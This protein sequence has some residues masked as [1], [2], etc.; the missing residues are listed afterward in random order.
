MA[1]LFSLPAKL[2]PSGERSLV[3]CVGDEEGLVTTVVIEATVGL[4]ELIVDDAS[5]GAI[6]NPVAKFDPFCMKAT[7]LGSLN[8]LFSS[9]QQLVVLPPLEQ[10]HS[11]L[12]HR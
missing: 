6:V 4:P 2:E 7:S 8:C 3:L 12:S 1:F 9:G 5:I 11:L 10:H